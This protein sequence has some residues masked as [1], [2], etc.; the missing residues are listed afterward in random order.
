MCSYLNWLT[1][2][3]IE[4]IR[5]TINEHINNAKILLADELST[6]LYGKDSVD[7]IHKYGLSKDFQSLQP[8]F[9]GATDIPVEE[10]DLFNSFSQ[11]VPHTRVTE[12]KLKQGIEFY[13]LLD[14]VRTPFLASGIF[15]TNKQSIRDG[16]CKI[17][18]RLETNI[19]YKITCEDVKSIKSQGGRTLNYIILQVGKRQ[20][21]F[22]LVEK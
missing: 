8:Y 21:Y 1:D 10:Y 9:N 18:G 4:K 15:Y 16:I 20:I 17:N 22:V 13:E 5:E 6:K 11:C 2:V 3:P 12:D 7:A 19:R 14:S